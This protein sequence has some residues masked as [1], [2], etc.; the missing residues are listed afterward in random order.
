[1][2]ARS[3]SRF[4]YL[5]AKLR[6][7]AWDAI[8]PHGPRVSIASR[9]YLIAMAIKGFQTELSEHTDV[10]T[11]GGVQKVLVK[12]AGERIV[13][14]FDDD[15]WC[16]TGKPRIPLPGPR[17]FGVSFDEVMLNPQPLPPKE[18]QREIG[19][20]L[21]MLSEATSVGEAAK[22]LGSIGNRLVNF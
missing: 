16:L 17:P 3:I 10:G 14:D 21:L 11:L 15:N 7:E 20:Y 5:I 1:M 12:F 18:L 22:E 4:L 13:A 9:E 6:P 8:Y 2:N 19:G